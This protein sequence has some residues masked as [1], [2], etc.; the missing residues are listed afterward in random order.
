MLTQIIAVA[1]QQAA[2]IARQPGAP[3]DVAEHTRAFARD[4]PPGVSAAQSAVRN[5]VANSRAIVERQLQSPPPAGDA[6]ARRAALRRALD[7]MVEEARTTAGQVTA[8]TGSLDRARTQFTTDQQ[9]L[10]GERAHAAARLEGARSNRDRLAGEV[11]KLR[12]RTTW[13]TIVGSFIWLVK[14][15]DEIVSAIQSGQSTEGALASAAQ[16][17]QNAQLDLGNLET[18]VQLFDTLGGLVGQLTGSVQNLANAM[19]FFLG[20]LTN[21][22]QFAA[23]ATPETATLFLTALRSSL[24]GLEEQAR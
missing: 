15:G 7:P 10:A 8:A 3:G 11:Q 13:T 4:V 1:A 2:T 24:D 16:E 20:T 23:I 5:F 22:E 18:T 21:Q 19:S 6:E 12:D 9:K 14:I 17:L